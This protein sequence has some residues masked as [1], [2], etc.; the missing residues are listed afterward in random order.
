[1]SYHGNIK[2]KEDKKSM[3]NIY[4][5]LVTEWGPQMLK[6]ENISIMVHSLRLTYTLPFGCDA[7][8]RDKKI[9]LC[10]F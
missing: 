6:Y 4:C 3:Q 5:F 8:P 10:C 2:Y 9:Y 1:M 7:R